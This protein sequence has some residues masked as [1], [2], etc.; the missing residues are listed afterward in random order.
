LL[1]HGGPDLVVVMVPW[2]REEPHPEKVIEEEEPAPE[3]PATAA[4]H[5]LGELLRSGRPER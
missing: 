5:M 2:T 3:Q 1:R 4:P